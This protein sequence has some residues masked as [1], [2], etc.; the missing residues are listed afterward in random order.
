MTD[1]PP[2]ADDADD[3]AALARHAAALADGIERALPG[4]CE[5]SVARLAA[6]WQPGL[7]AALA[8]PAAEAGRRAAAEIGPEV[9]SLLALD[10]D[11][12]AANPLA[13]VRRAVVHPTAILE[14]AGVPPIERDEFAERAFPDDRYGLS[15]AS[16]AELDESLRE[17][18]LIWGAA[19]AHVVLARRR[20]EG[21]R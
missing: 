16:F 10:V 3:L 21:R 19:K 12:Q 5:R 4:W 1:L 2:P 7:A 13:L 15:P 9:R 17:L 14:A 8:E 20:R 11:D 18:G 6:A